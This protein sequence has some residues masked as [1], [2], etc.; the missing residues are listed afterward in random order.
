MIEGFEKISHRE[1]GCLWRG[2]IRSRATGITAVCR[3]LDS[4]EARLFHNSAKITAGVAGDFFVKR[5]NLPGFTVQIRR[6][7]KPSRPLV[8]LRGAAH[9][10]SLSIPTPRVIGALTAWRGLSR[11]EYLVTALLG[12]KE[13]LCDDLLRQTSAAEVWQVILHKILPMLAKL[14]DSGALHGD[15]NLRNIYIDGSGAAGLIDLDGMKIGSGSLPGYARALEIGRL[16]SGFMAYTGQRKNFSGL[17]A[18]VLQS[19]GRLTANVP[20]EKETLA[21][22]EKFIRRMEKYL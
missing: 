9:L 18:E 2:F 10:E 17:V 21:V 15:L 7:F 3:D 14:H 16:I 6:L 4:P 8:V 5:Y 22:T 12:E 11:R 19:Y 20:D 13:H 1:S